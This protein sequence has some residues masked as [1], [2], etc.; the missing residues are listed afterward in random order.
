MKS[1]Y[2]Y[3]QYKLIYGLRLRKL[4]AAVSIALATNNVA[5]LLN[6]KATI[7]LRAIYP[8]LIVPNLLNP[9][10]PFVSLGLLQLCLA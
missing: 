10:V 7:T 1:T 2:K 5:A 6:A 4:S 3:C 8:R 9:L